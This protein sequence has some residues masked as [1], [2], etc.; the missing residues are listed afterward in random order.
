M[1]EFD[2]DARHRRRAAGAGCSVSVVDMPEARVPVDDDASRAW[3]EVAQGARMSWHMFRNVAPP[4]EGS[5][6]ARTRELYPFEPLD[7]RAQAY[8]G[9]AL[10]HLMMWAEYTAPLKFHPDQESSFYQRP[11]YTLARAALEAA[12]QA[13]WMLDTLD[14]MECIRRHL[15]LMRWDLHEH[16]RSKSALDEKEVIDARERE[17]LTRVANV[18]TADDIKPPSSYLW[19]LRAA[20]RPDDLNLQAEEV[21]RLWRAASGSAHGMYWPTQDLQRSVA[22]TSSDGGVRQIRVADAELVA[23]VLNAAYSMTQYAVLKYAQFSGADIWSLI[24]ASRRWLTSMIT[25]R[26]DAD[27]DVVA[28]LLGGSASST[29]SGAQPDL[30]ALEETIAVLSDPGT[31]K[32]LAESDAD[33]AAGR[34]ETLDEVQRTM[35]AR[36]SGA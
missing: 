9:A 27:S 23:Q 32:A 16:K 34:L 8:V 29:R 26:E 25:L 3:T 30:E 10:E 7:E 33:I 15:S 5:N 2:H 12:A 4:T 11:P 24:E 1:A 28:R 31:M 36:P 20:C 35:R 14:P 19:V 6:F 17:L 18:F 13:V 22:V 21:E